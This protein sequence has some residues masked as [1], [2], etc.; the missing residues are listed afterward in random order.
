M[1]SLLLN[2]GCLP[3]LTT[4]VAAASIHTPAVIEENET[5]VTV[6]L[7]AV[8][9]TLVIRRRYENGMEWNGNGEYQISQV[10]SLF[11][12]ILMIAE[13]KGKFVCMFYIMI[14]YFMILFICPKGK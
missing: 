9:K 2:C 4:P 11:S 14:L 8:A 6:C 12:P 5:T 10:I 3:S 13:A 7:A 1:P